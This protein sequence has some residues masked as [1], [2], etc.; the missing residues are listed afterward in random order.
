MKKIF[1]IN[2][3]ILLFFVCWIVFAE[4]TKGILIK[5]IK[6]NE[7]R[8]WAVCIGINDYWDDTIS[9]LKKAQ[10]D[11][12]GLSEIFNTRGQFDNVY[13]MTDDLDPKDK[14]YPSKFNIEARIDYIIK[15]AQKNDL[16]IFAFSGHGIADQEG[17]SYLVPADVRPDNPFVTSCAL[18][19]IVTRLK[20]KEIKKSLLFIDACREEMQQSKSL[21]SGGFSAPLY[22]KAEIAAIFYSTKAGWYSYEDKMSNYGI[23]TRFLIEGLKG[24][25]NSDNNTIVSFSELEIYAMRAVYDYAIELDLRQCPYTKIYGE[26]FGD[27]A[28][29]S[30]IPD[31]TIV[32]EGDLPEGMV[33][34]KAGSF[35]M[36]SDKGNYI[37]KPVHT[38]RITKDFLMGKYEVTF[39]EWDLFCTETGTEKPEDN[40]WG[41]GNLPVI[42]VSWNEVVEYCNWKSKKEGL[43]PCY[44]GKWN[45]ITCDFSKDGYRLPTEAEWEYAARGGNMGKNLL[46]PGSNNPDD[47]SWFLENSGKRTAI[48]GTKKPNELG[49]YDMSGNVREWC[50]DWYWEPYDKKSP[51][52]DPTGPVTDHGRGDRVV[53]GGSYFDQKEYIRCTSRYWGGQSAYSNSNG[54]RLVRTVSGK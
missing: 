18:D 38:V 13:T 49:L 12:K 29:T 34:V 16:F 47:V 8:R 3:Y 52:S 17:K 9:D 40:E 2:L 39:A 42:Q 45:T 24:K 48:V 35:E 6:G 51:V 25:A 31:T 53:R 23:F 15:M 4:D 41:R 54:F 11:A 10:N 50:W 27:L 26:K 22:S 20:E 19:Y 7:G 43:T 46:Y 21:K 37:E 33:L 44:K 14:N 1:C 28:L 32:K 30:V 36:G 5:E